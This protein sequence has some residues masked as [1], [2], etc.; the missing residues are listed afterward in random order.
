[1]VENQMAIVASANAALDRLWARVKTLCY[2]P[3]LTLDD[4]DAMT[5]E[6]FLVEAG[7]AISRH[8]LKEERD[9]V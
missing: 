8:L 2:K 7:L 1:M 5:A 9:S 6:L 3:A 4:I